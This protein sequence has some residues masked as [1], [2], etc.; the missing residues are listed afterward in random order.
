VNDGNAYSSKAGVV[1]FTGNNLSGNTVIGGTGTTLFNTLIV[2][3]KSSNLQLDNNISVTDN[4]VMQSGN[5]QLNNHILDLGRTG[6][7]TGERNDSRIMGQDHGLVTVTATLSAPHA[8]NPGNI[9]VEITS[10]SDLGTIKIARGHSPQMSADGDPGIDRYFSITADHNAGLDATLKFYYLDA[11]VGTDSKNMLSVFTRQNTWDTWSAKGKDGSDASAN[12]VV[13][14]H[15][16]N[17]GNY[18]LARSS[19]NLLTREGAN[20]MLQ[21]FPNP[22]IDHFN[23]ILESDLETDDMISLYDQNGHLLQVKKVHLFKGAN[24][25]EWM[26]GKYAAGTYFL[27]FANSQKKMLKIVKL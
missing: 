14:N 12:W 23:L 24:T 20:K 3:T 27:S 8:V 9:G 1:S 2:D 18:T 25:L 10:L 11:E 5:L 15:L 7:I 16:D 17:L 26:E 21:V 6:Y 22:Y 4:L 19:G 13:K